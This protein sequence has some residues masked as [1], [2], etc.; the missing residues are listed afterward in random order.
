VDGFDNGDVYTGAVAASFSQEA[1]REFQVLAASTPA[2]FG[3]ASG[4]TVNTVTK[5][6]TNQWHGSAFFFLRDKAL[7]AKEHFEEQDV[8]GNPLDAPKASFHQDQWGATLGGPLRRDRTF[9]F[10]SFER[11]AADASNFV[12]IDT[13]TAEALER[14]GFPVE[15][16]S[17]PYAQERW[18][19]LAKL[20]ENLAPNHRVTVR[21]HVSER[22]NENLEPFGGIVARSRG[23]ELQRTD[24]ALAV[25]AS[26]VFRSGW[27]NESRLQVVRGDQATYGL[28]PRCGGP[29]RE[30]D[31]GGPEITLPGLAVAGRQLNTPQARAN[32]N[33]QL[34]DTVTA[35]FGRHTAKA[36]FD[37]DLVWRDGEFAQDFGGRYVF[38]ALPAIPGFTSRPLTSLE[39]FELGLP[40]VYLQG[41]GT[42][43]AAGTSR[44][45]SAFAQDR[46]RPS[47]R[48]T[49]EAGLRYQWYSLGMPPV[50]VS[51]VGG[52]TFTYQVPNRGDLAPR[53]ALTFDPTRRG[54]T[55]LRGAFG[56]FHEDP[57]LA[58]AFVTDFANGQTLRF[59][60]AG[61]PL[62]AEAWRSPGHRLPEPMANFPSLVQVASP[63]FRVPYSRQLSLGWTQAIGE[64][65]TVSV[66]G[67]AV[68]GHRQIGVLD[69]NPLLP[70]L[71]PGRRPDDV[72]GRAGT[73]ASVN[74]FANYGESWY[75]GL[76]VVV[77]KRMSHGFEAQASYTLSKAEDLVSE[78][79]GQANI[80]E[81]P[82]AGR[83]PLDRAG[84][85]LGFAPDSFRGPSAVDQRHR[86]VLS[87]LGRL[88]W[89]LELSGIV[90]VGSSR[91]FTALS[92]VD[93]N[94][95]GVAATDRARRDPR[96][97]ASRVV[98]NGESLPGTATVDMRLSRRFALS[99]GT[100]LEV[101]VEAFNLFDRVNYNEVN[102]VFGPGAFP[103]DPQRDGAGRV[104]YGLFTKALPPRQVQIA[105]RLT[106]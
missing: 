30:V 27:L 72:D 38:T 88:P 67:L 52:T 44:M 9:A 25:S 101:L 85:P 97:A 35:T 66:D 96:D 77:R 84:L 73:S 13:A 62:A 56:L 8:F 65:L 50:T 18:S 55:T 51:D 106:F 11:Q 17:V 6:G 104:T 99:R 59:L 105:T 71:G 42:T 76:A 3:H 57:M 100:A 103:D 31:E 61:L 7:N 26:D 39:A 86:C 37:L 28:D 58:V 54:R 79:F 98:R 92:G 74:H 60:R 5:G 90:T 47:S 75:R 95:D 15:L 48:L 69:Y 2:E 63:S 102:N 68:R 34:A 23:V 46:W 70:S 22:R 20:E 93:S 29:C 12:T 41:Y 19:A 87:A 1:V 53:L 64:E 83:D 14:A 36:G 21:A 80:A 89:R 16:G 24:W 33:V 94:G 10:A 4:G 91:P 49:I 81:D 82:G 32:L 78:P 43:T 40:A 45:F